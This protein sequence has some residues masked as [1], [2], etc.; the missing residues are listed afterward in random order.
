MSWR[1]ELS[2][3]RALFRRPKL[4]DDLKAE[5]RSHVAMEERENLEAGM[6]P[7]EAHY[8]ALRRFGNVT[9]AQERS[10][11][12]WGWNSIETLFQDLRYGL[13]QL[14]RSPGFA[15]V[16]VITLALGIGAN[17]AIFSL[18][19][20]I[21]L[22]SLP[23]SH[24]QSLVVLASYS[25]NG[26]VGDFGY[27]D[28]LIVR[29]GSRAFSG[30]L[31]ASSQERINAGI[32][33]ETEVALREI[34]SANY[35]SVLGV[36]P[37]L[38]RVFRNG[39]QNLPVAVIS[40][41]F[42]K[43]T[44]AG[45]PSVVGQQ[46]DL[47]GLPFT[48]V[49]VAPPGF[50]GETVGEA[51]DIWVTMSLMPPERRSLPGFTWL[52]LMARLKPGVQAQQASADLSLLL[53]QL[54]DSES[55][56]GFIDRVAVEPGGQGASG[57]RDSFSAPLGILMAVVAVVLL[58]ACTNLASLH[59]ARASTRQ[60]E[61]A[62]RLALGAGRGRVL[63]Q[64]LTESILLAALGGL[65]GLLFA[66]WTERLLLSLVA[67]VGPAITLDLR[68]DLHM[69]G[70]TA[71][72]S[73]ATGVLFGLAPALHAVRQEVGLV[74]KCSPGARAAGGKRWRLRDWLITVQ[75]ALSLLL[76]VVGGLFIRTL[77]DLKNQDV[78]FRAA[79][80]LSVELR[81][82]RE[83]QPPRARAIV[84]LLQRVQS[85][86]G[87]LVGSFSFT[88]IL[89]DEA[90]HVNGLKFDEYPP[91]RE[92][93]RAQANWVGADYFR[94][95]GIALLEGREFSL[96]DNSNA[97]EVAILNQTMARRYFGNEPALGKRFEFNKKHYEIIGVAKDAKYVDLRESNVPFV[98]FAALQSNSEIQTL[99]LRTK[100]HPLAVASAVRATIRE[101]DPYLRIAEITTLEKRVDQKLGFEFLVRDIAGFF[102]GLTLLLVFVGIY[103]T[104]TYAVARRTS[105]VGVRMALGA[106]KS[107]VLRL[108][109]GQGMI[110][111]LIGV[112]IGVGVALGVTHLL[113]GLLYG[114]KPTDPLTFGLVSLIL[115]SVALLACWVPARRAAKVDPM[116]AL[117]HE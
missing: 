34:V 98:Y 30:V 80:V 47:D 60:R 85:V 61:I 107:D 113:S 115:I 50:F 70:F 111:T 12:M 35:F 68:P 20:T 59:L 42:W 16:A 97:Q 99:E 65:L 62:T 96:A 33:A 55:R 2:K 84:P 117:R 26:K 81:S 31:A 104:L 22:K 90:S 23:V 72:I 10:R 110:L 28:Y 75:V 82:E 105:E 76:S 43:R 51:P 19:D 56:G 83:R 37:H 25:K 52:D 46:V 36:S 13:R 100:G 112:V 32:G 54:P 48:V 27:Q 57:L 102:S 69:L 66:I 114:V 73:V 86:P 1:R 89:A 9:L 53:P 18:L 40:N 88:P 7:E 14:R 17:T 101:A 93:Q 11:D 38:G 103:G 108:V 64:L 67:A 63:R 87:V 3:L 78:G 109:V 6:L 79:N 44:F 106:Q 5:I 74:L 92:E 116:L 24:P 29:D 39:D 49:G 41:R 4:A 95:S 15:A 8:A 21:L 71:A 91:T 58:I 45:S 94:T 77:R